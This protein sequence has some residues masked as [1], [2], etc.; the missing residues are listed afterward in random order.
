MLSIPLVIRR[1]LGYLFAIFIAGV[2]PVMAADSVATVT[3]AVN[4]VSHGSAQSAETAPAK[5]GTQIQDGEYLKTGV[6]SR[7]ELQLANQSITRL[8]ANT[9][10][11]YSVANNEVDL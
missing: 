10:F 7:A 5:T 1:L 4:E 3:E 6:K 11:N 8:G 2:C 9:I